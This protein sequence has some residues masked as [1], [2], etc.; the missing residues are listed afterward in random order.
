MVPV[1][2]LLVL[3]GLPLTAVSLG[4]TGDTS[5][6]ALIDPTFDEPFNPDTLCGS[7][8]LGTLA[9]VASLVLGGC[10]LLV[11]SV[12]G[13][14]GRVPLEWGAWLLAAMTAA[15]AAI[16]ALLT[17]RL[18]SWHDDVLVRGWTPV[19]N[20]AGYTAVGV[21]LALAVIVATFTLD[22]ADEH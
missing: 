8:H 20:L 12:L 9:I 22:S 14:L 3:C 21:G 15:S 19:R 11:F 6:G 2:L 17:W 18:T 4:G 16:A 5:C 13:A 7:M 1:G 10:V